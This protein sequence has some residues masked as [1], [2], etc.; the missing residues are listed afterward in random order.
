MSKWEDWKK[1]LGD[2]RPWHILD[3]NRHVSDSKISENRLKICAGCEFYLKTKQ[4]SKCGCIM[5]VK[6][7]LAEAE[8]PVGKWGKENLQ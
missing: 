1:S 5:P 4:C 7:Q 3:P 2:S 8:C 6:V